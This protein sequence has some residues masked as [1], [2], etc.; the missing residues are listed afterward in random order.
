MILAIL[1]PQGSGKGTQAALLVEKFNLHNLDVG[2]ML[3]EMAKTNP[4][5][6]AIV[7]KRGELMPDGKVFEIVKEYLTKKNLVDNILFD[8][9]PRS[10]EQYNY[11]SSYLMQKARKFDGVIFLTI[12]DEV[13]IE[14]LSSRRIHKTTGEIYNLITNPPE[15][16]VNLDDL[17]QREDDKPE[18]IRERLKMYHEQTQPLIEHLK[19]QGLVIEVDGTKPIDVVFE[20]ICQSLI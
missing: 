18:A 17:E 11:M 16:G 2:A 15:S 1:G 14:R 13:A 3:R 8:G 12:P 7:N 19:S 10:V 20:N 9:Y 6:D 4:E 5:I